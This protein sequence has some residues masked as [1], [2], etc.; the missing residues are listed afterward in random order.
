VHCHSPHIILTYRSAVNF[1]GLDSLSLQVSDGTNTSLPVEVTIMMRSGAETTPPKVSVTY[2]VQGAAD[3]E[4]FR[5]PIYESVHHPPIWAQ[6]T[7]P[8]S[9]RTVTTETLFVVTDEGS[10]GNLR[11][12]P[13]PSIGGHAYS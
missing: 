13:R 9:A 5:T 2:P 8:I 3:V 10:A 7:E 6:F 4:V 12:R 11:W 1:E